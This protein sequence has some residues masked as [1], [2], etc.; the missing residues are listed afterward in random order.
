MPFGKGARA[1]RS[2][3]RKHQATSERS[4]MANDQMHDLNWPLLQQMIKPS[5]VT[6]LKGYRPERCAVAASTIQNTYPP[7]E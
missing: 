1:A 3:C 4:G 7:G 2:I 5:P 6:S